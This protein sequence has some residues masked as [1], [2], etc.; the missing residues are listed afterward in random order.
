MKKKY[1]IGLFVLIILTIFFS[2]YTSSEKSEAEETS[3]ENGYFLYEKNGFVVVYESDQK[4]PYEYTD[5]RYDELPD[6]LQNE[7][8]KGKYVKTIEELYGFLENYSS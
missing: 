6:S 4:T 8:K 5:I 2:F 7:I 3:M 1:G